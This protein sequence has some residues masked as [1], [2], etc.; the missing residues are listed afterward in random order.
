MLTVF[1]MQLTK[2]LLL[3]TLQ[4][5][6]TLTHRGPS[7]PRNVSVTQ[8]FSSQTLSV[9]WMSDSTLF[10]IEIFRTDL[11]NIVLN[12]TV[13]PEADPVS[14][15]FGWTWKSK[16]PLQCTS[17]SVQIRAR[18]D[19]SV[20]EWSPL[21]TV[22]GSDVRDKAQMF[23]QDKVV[24][25]GSNVSFCCIMGKEL[26]GSI[27]TQNK[28][29]E[30]TALDSRTFIATA[31]NLPQ[32]RA[33]GTNIICTSS[34]AV[35]SGAVVFVGYPPGDE[36][37]VCETRDL[38]GAVCHWRKGRDTGFIKK[39]LLT[40]YTVNG[41]PC[42]EAK[43]E[44]DEKVC[45]F[46][47]WENNWTLIAENA[48]GK[49]QLH[50]FAHII[51]R[52]RLFAP[53]NFSADP[54]A[55]TSN[56]N[57]IWTV[58]EYK[59]LDMKCEVNFTT[60]GP[61][62]S[63]SYEGVGLSTIMLDGLRPDQEYSLYIRCGS[64]LRFW[65]WGD[66]SAPY[67]FRTKID[68]PESPDVWVWRD[69]EKSGQIL[70]KQLSPSDTHG[71]LT[72]YEV[73][74]RDRVEDDWKILPVLPTTFHFPITF[75]NS[76]DDVIVAVAAR[77][78]A[79][80]SRL[81][82]MPVPEFQADSQIK[83]RLL[84]NGGDLELTWQPWTNASLGYVVEWVPT[85]CV[86]NCT[87]QWLKIPEA[88]TSATIQ[89]GSLEVGV[90][91]TLSVFALN[92]EA[93][94]LIQR[95]RVYG[96]ELVPVR[97]VKSL[98]AKQSGKDVLLTWKPETIA[99]QRGFIKGY[100]IYLVNGSHLELIG[101]VPDPE[102]NSYTVKG[103]N[104][105]FYKFTVKGYT[106]AG[107]GGGDTVAIKVSSDS[108][109]LV[110][111]LVA[112]GLMSFCLIII[113]VFCFTK[114]EWVKKAFYPEIPGPKLAGD[115]TAPPAPLDVKPPPHSLVHI[116][117]SPEW[118]SGKIFSV[119]EEEEVE[120]DENVEVDTD[121]DDPALLRYYNQLVSDDCNN[122][123]DTS[124]S[125]SGSEDSAQTQVT[126]TGLQSPTPG[127]RPQNQPPGVADENQHQDLQENPSTGYRPQCTWQ[128]DSPG[129]DNLSG[130]LGSPTSVT[131]SQFL[132]PENAE[133]QPDPPG[134]WFHNLLSGKL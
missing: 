88:N 49:V 121:S 66:W 3:L 25:V 100:I 93:T 2:A 23:P 86:D 64:R 95:H 119:P 116:V 27:E 73:H 32:S 118:D 127:Y 46:E 110:E 87:V 39:S 120:N 57:W 96:E 91:Y 1:I 53:V 89:S 65:K 97:S 21:Q 131:S 117:E 45:H 84:G 38:Q 63:R 43:R 10:D 18:V 115:W 26:F 92:D 8:D 78:L 14:G 15:Q 12:E 108:D 124:G 50:D 112:L 122:T 79:G 109:L 34:Y 52:V 7:V 19:K 59:S 111:I 102:L 5:T 55:W 76:I 20:S 104:L 48:L 67:Q 80:R 41:R 82:A 58:P 101:K 68:C 4:I 36:N 133:D 56:I 61:P 17:H 77:N 60:G 37:L 33:T 130:S 13:S 81:T 90:Q 123:S 30:V 16:I 103:L 99:N 62:S 40:R 44:K 132:L 134:T 35:I 125:S 105:G 129:S 106:S 126:Y 29:L 31:T 9:T 42:R 114:R 83:S 24:P 75:G 47:R 94:V 28:K 22:P 69:S 71:A 51:N 128:P 98:S 6:Y 72:M 85:G 74:Q 70:W 54:K 11:K 107:E 113:S